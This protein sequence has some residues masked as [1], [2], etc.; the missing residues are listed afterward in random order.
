MTS[1]WRS[2]DAFQ[3]VSTTLYN[4]YTWYFIFLSFFTPGV[5]NKYVALLWE[6]SEVF[7]TYWSWDI[8]KLVQ[9]TLPLS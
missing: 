9:Y 7:S 8:M 2:G 3:G 5:M 6:R 4:N 1:G